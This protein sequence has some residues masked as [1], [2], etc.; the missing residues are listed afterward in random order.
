ML[1]RLT[2][3]LSDIMPGESD[4]HAADPIEG[5]VEPKDI[6]ATILHC[7]GLSPTTEY[8]D[9]EGRPLPLSRGRVIDEI[10]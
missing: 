2:G 5:K 6:T 10:L 4:K 9:D 3:V 1:R 7:L 8:H